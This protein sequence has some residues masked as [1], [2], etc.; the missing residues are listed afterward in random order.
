MVR[1]NPRMETFSSIKISILLLHNLVMV[2]PRKTHTCITE[3]LL[4]GR[5]E[6]NQQNKNFYTN[7]FVIM[8]IGIGSI[9]NFQEELTT[10]ELPHNIA[11]KVSCIH[12]KDSDQPGHL[13]T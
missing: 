9:R 2:Q 1:V 3:R 4:M 10:H 11:K 6:S 7:I 13:S 8:H 12:S 5:K